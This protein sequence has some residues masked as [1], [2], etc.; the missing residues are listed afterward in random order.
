MYR[1]TWYPPLV[2]DAFADLRE[3]VAF[4]VFY[5]KTKIVFASPYRLSDFLKGGRSNQEHFRH[6]ST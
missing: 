5:L 6:N 1:S 2:I 4:K 3:L